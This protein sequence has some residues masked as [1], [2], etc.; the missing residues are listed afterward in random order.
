MY[1][2]FFIHTMCIYMYRYI[3][4]DRPL[5][6]GPSDQFKYCISVDLNSFL[7]STVKPTLITPKGFP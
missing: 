4:H 2:L 6:W 5:H 1:Y 3:F 7:R